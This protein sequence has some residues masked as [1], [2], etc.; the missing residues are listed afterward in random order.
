VRARFPDAFTAAAPAKP[1]DAKL[2]RSGSLTTS[3]SSSASSS[4]DEARNARLDAASLLRA[5]HALSGD[6]V[7]GSLLERLLRVL[8]E[9]AGAEL[10]ALVLVRDGEL[11]LRAQLTVEPERLAADLDEPVE[12]SPR[13]PATLVQYVARSM[14]PVVLGQAGSDNRF[15]DDPYLC[16]R[17]PASV[18]AVPL[19]HRGRLS[20][21]LYLEHSRAADAFPESRIET[22]SLLASQAAT[23]VENATLYTELQASNERLE[24][25]VENRT[26]QLKAAKEAAD[27]AN[28]AKSDFLAS[29]SHELRTPLN[30]ILGYA[31]ILD[32]SPTI[33]AQDREGVR[34]IRQSG[35]HLLALINDVLDLA[36]VEAGKLELHPR[37]VD[38]PTLLRTVASLS[39]VRADQKGI[40]FTCELPEQSLPVVR[41]DEKRLTQVLLNLVG[42]AIKFTER[43]SVRLRAVV[44]DDHASPTEDGPTRRTVELSVEDTGPGI[45]PEHLACIFD[46]FEQVGDAAKRAEGTGLGLAI[47]RRIVDRMGGSIGVAS[48]LGKGSTFTVTLSLP[49]ATSKAA[50]ANVASWHQ[51]TGYRGERRTLLIVDDSRD[52]L[53]LLRDLLSPLGFETLE[54]EGGE[55]ALELT[56]ARR[57]ALILMDLAMPGMD[58]HE[59]TRRLRQRPELAQVVIIATSASV[60]E[61]EYRK[62]AQ[63]GCN[64][65]LPK[66]VRA[67]QLLEMLARHL[68]LE[69]VLRGASEPAPME[70][71]ESTALLRPPA[72]VVASLLE[73]A[74]Q[75]RFRGLLDEVQRLEAEDRRFAPWLAKLHAIVRQ[76]QVKAVREFLRQASAE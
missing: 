62:S 24:G 73:L 71:R 38:L 63:A 12:G 47:T 40:T 44:L 56:A 64:D 58:G 51:I 5:A 20:G 10:A 53:A 14:E 21:V 4:H 7:L 16:A 18:L 17:R 65:F 59:V 69:W 23:A 32:R 3:A 48:E 35:E 74:E 54:A 19:L 2:R 43:G 45:G 11:R 70:E 9:N 34:V 42:N 36:K 26:A 66:P 72:E 50:A 6:M 28:Q 49:E 52:N 57:P 75:G 41:V 25:L 67:E 22:V 13:L 27:K 60:S 29:M 30:G 8:A 39:Q 61:A 15:D 68:D 55:Q 46:P 33:G 31:Q 1:S 37:D 76:F